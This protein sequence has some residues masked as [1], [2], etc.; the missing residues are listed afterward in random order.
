MVKVCHITSAHDPEDI[1]IFQKECISLK[2]NG[3]DVYLVERGNSYVK[4]GV[5]IIG[6]GFPSGGRLSRMTTF[7]RKTYR[8]ALDVDADIYHLHDP[9]LLVY[10]LKL[11]RKGKKVIFDSHEKYSEQLKRKPYL[12]NWCSRMI[13]AM[14]THFEKYVLKKIDGLIFPS[15]RNGVHPFEGMCRHITTVNNVPRLEEL[16]DRYDP[17]AVKKPNSIVYIGGLSHPRG[18]TSLVKAAGIANCTVYLGGAFSPPSYEDDL[19]RLP[20]FSCVCHLGQLSR[21]QVLETTQ[22]C[23]IGYSAS[24]FAG[25]YNKDDN[26]ATKAYECMSLGLPVILTCSPYNKKITQQY[27]FGICVD[28]SNPEEI[29][30]AIQYLLENPEE[31]RRMGENGRRAIK[32]EFN[33]GVEEQK[34]FALYEDILKD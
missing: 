10:A 34:L 11:K 13:A 6:V 18:I 17:S 23:L 14:Y 19:K 9:E 5:H 3:Y 12:P 16:Y 20:E 15:L 7:A 27:E 2:E 22:S 26:L 8:A 30:A 32:E 1:R 24:L 33:W 29:A 21:P 31:A 4:N 25:Q 28:P